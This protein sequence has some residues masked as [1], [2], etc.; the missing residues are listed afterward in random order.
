MA[1]LTQWTWVWVNSW[2]WWWTGKPGVLQSIG[3]QRV[4]H[5]WATELNFVTPWVAAHQPPLSFTISWSLLKFMLL[6]S[7]I[8]SNQLILCHSPF[9]FAFNLSQHAGLFQQVGSLLQ[10]AKVLEL[11][12]QHQSFQWILGLI[13][14]RVEWF[15]L[16]VQGTLESP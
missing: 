14:C 12:L 4:R 8:L 2:S 11:Q 10:V 5:D 15:D 9:P 3:S 13:S 16:A 6:E 1:S 7:V